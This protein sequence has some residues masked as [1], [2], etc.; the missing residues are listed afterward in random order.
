M[1]KIHLVCNAHLD[2][3]W[4]WEW[5]E[6]AA[7]TISTF[8]IA[9]D[10]CDNY[11]GFV[12][13]H[14]EAILY[15]WI[16]EYDS[17]LFERIQKLVKAGKWHIMGGWYLQPDCNMPSGESF[18]R[19]ILLGRNYFRDKFGKEPTTAINF[20][21][22]GHTRGLVQILAKSGFDSYLFCRPAQNDCKLENDAFI[23]EGY[24]GSRVKALRAFDM[25]LTLRGEAVNKVKKHINNY[26]ANDIG[27]VLWG[28]GNHGGGPSKIDYEALDK[29]ASDQ[30]KINI[31][32][33]TPENYF[34][35]LDSNTLPVHRNDL[36]KWAIGCYTSQIRLKQQHRKLENELYSTEKM[37]TSAWVQKLLSY[38]EHDLK[39]AQQD[40]AFA[41]FHDILPGSAIQPVEDTSLRLMAHGQEILSR[42]KAR[43]FFALAG[44]Q[45]KAKEHEIPILVYNP[46]SYPVK[47]IIDCEFNLADQNWKNTFMDVKVYA[48]NKC[49]PSQVEK[50]YSNLHLDWRKKVVFEAELKPSMMNR[51]DCKIIELPSKPNKELE[52]TADDIL[53]SDINKT[54]AISKKT[55]L[56]TSYKVNGY[57]FIEKP[58]CLPIVLEDNEDSWIMD[59]QEFGKKIG[60]FRLLT[61]KETAEYLGLKKNK[62]EAVRVIENGQ[63]R[64]VVEAV[65]A[66]KHSNIC[67]QYKIPKNST[68][69]EISA[70]VCWAEKNKLLKLTFN[71]AKS[72]EYLGQVACGTEYFPSNGQEIVFHKWLIAMNKK[73]KNAFSIINDGIY[74][75]NFKDNEIGLTLLRSPVYSGH[76]FEGHDIVLQDRFIPHHDQGERLYTFWLNAGSSEKRINHI[77]REA[78]VKNEKPMALSF[79][80]SGENKNNIKS[81]LQLND[82]SIQ[83]MAIK[84]STQ[85]ENAIVIRLFENTGSSKETVLSSEALG[86][87]K[88]IKLS[89]FEIKTF[90]VNIDTKSVIEVNLIEQ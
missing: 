84:K 40:L 15:Q 49:L 52:E 14:N 66:Y 56:M 35:E 68:E 54:I 38:P 71:T 17:L 48:E 30:K 77:D 27:L 89:A 7:E 80:P 41:E 58:S 67:I 34:K 19:Q 31:I 63:T 73:S 6:G 82:N 90:E 78:L 79:F 36:N 46:H 55:G 28:I 37:L 59:K 75:A 29:F 5:E 83:V 4:L 62:L 64:V 70:R 8:R 81:L 88:K 60:E 26:P 86:F 16:E 43:A 32:H 9:A 12:F 87:Y 1:R 2:P 3:V 45:R 51:F 85:K 22:F 50:E 11:D 23:W 69:I 20:D 76:P 74:G 13:N 47:T 53:L 33:S 39:Q 10:F 42:L 18:I 57:D 65:F 72:N 44:N 21:P 24:D 61:E 25:Y